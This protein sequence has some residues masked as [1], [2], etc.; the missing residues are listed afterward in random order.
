LKILN[1]YKDKD[2]LS[3]KEVANWL[4]LSIPSI[5][6]M[7]KSGVIKHKRIG[8]KYLIPKFCVKDFLQSARYDNSM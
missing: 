6:K 1:N 4:N 7:L 3:P 8:K 5:Y 2:V